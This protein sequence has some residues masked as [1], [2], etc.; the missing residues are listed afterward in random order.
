MANPVKYVAKKTGTYVAQRVTYAVM[1]RGAKRL[2]RMYMK[3][4]PRRAITANYKAI[5]STRVGLIGRSPRGPAAKPA[6]PRNDRFGNFARQAGRIA[7]ARLTMAGT[8]RYVGNVEAYRKTGALPTGRDA[9]SFNS[10]QGS[11]KK[12]AGG[13]FVGSGG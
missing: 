8:R 12:G 10:R 6:T 3:A 5:G 11:W 7:V 9:G 1:K 13:R 2:S 4:N